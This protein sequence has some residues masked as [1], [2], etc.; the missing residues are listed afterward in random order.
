MV[1][2]FLTP[3]F[4]RETVPAPRLA[5]LRARSQFAYFADHRPPRVPWGHLVEIFIYIAI[6]SGMGSVG[7]LKTSICGGV[8]IFNVRP[9][10]LRSRYRLD[11]VFLRRRCL[12]P[13]L[14]RASSR[15]LFS[16]LRPPF[17]V[18]AS[19]RKIQR[20]IYDHTYFAA[21]SR[22]RPGFVRRCLLPRPPAPRRLA[23]CL[24]RRSPTPASLW[25][26]LVEIYIYVYR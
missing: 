25:G 6:Y 13:P 21:S 17:S 4:F 20:H 2:A 24:F 14:L 23:L 10:P 9:L 12:L 5:P 1:R 22:D 15:Q 8:C 26:H 19:L 16:G 3:R 11:F 18:R 7:G